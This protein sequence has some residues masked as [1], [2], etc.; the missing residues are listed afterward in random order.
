MGGS[1]V[2]EISFCKGK[3]QFCIFRLSCTRTKGGF[4]IEEYDKKNKVFNPLSGQGAVKIDVDNEGQVWIV[5][6]SGKVFVA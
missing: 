6:E 2:K 5:T 3:K 1:C 4:Q